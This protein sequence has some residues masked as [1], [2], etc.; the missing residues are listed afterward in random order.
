MLDAYREHVA[1][2][3]ALGIPPTPLSAAQVAEV[4]E[5]LNAPPE[6]EAD[7]LLELIT[8]RVQ[9]DVITTHFPRDPSDQVEDDRRR[10]WRLRGAL[11]VS[12]PDPLVTSA[13]FWILDPQL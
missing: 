7:F 9:E 1:E 2:R 13:L 12:E 11:K 6:G 10:V 4:T 8:E 5:L 3:A